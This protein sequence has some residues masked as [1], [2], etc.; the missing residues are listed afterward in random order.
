MCM[1]HAVYHRVIII[2]TKSSNV[3]ARVL[4]DLFL[5]LALPLNATQRCGVTVSVALRASL[6]PLSLAFSFP[7]YKVYS[8]NIP[9]FTRLS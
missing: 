9:Y 7:I 5:V 6:S 8:M 3:M 4:E 2:I 1:V